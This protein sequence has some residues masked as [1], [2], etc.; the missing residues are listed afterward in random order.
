LEDTDISQ[1]SVATRL[2][3]N[4]IYS[5]SFIANCLLILTV[6]KFWKSVNIWWSY[7]VYKKLCRFL[8][9]PVYWGG[10]ERDL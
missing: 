4:R 8:A 2:G 6:K 1:G 5:G 10:R 3:C 7:E 9:Q